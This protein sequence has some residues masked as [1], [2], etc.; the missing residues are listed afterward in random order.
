MELKKHDRVGYI[1]TRFNR[2]RWLT[3]I[4]VVAPT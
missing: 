4:T 1:L 2:D 3:L